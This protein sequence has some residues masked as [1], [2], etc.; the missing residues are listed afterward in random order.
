MATWKKNRRGVA[1]SAV[2]T[3][4]YIAPEVFDGYGYG[5]ECDY[6]SLGAILYECLVGFPPFC[7]N[8]SQ[9]TYQKI[10]NWRRY[11]HL[12]EGVHLSLEAQDLIGRYT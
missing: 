8:G 9:E 10:I 4:D 7:S 2:G 3:P 11:L 5:R 12:P 6:W 1:Y